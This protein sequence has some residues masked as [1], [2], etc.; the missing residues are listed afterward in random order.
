MKKNI[1]IL[2]SLIL[3]SI[4]INSAFTKQSYTKI[5]QVSSFVGTN[6][7][8]YSSI[9]KIPKNY[10]FHFDKAKILKFKI[11]SVSD[12]KPVKFII[13]NL[14]TNTT[15]YQISEINLT[16][17]MKTNLEPGNYE[18]YIETMPGKNYLN[19]LLT[20]NDL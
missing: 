5:S 11:A 3:F 15:L 20:L 2:I 17:S 10:N 1:Y 8:N 19:Y 14:N 7:S 9:Q 12:K 16:D 4:S 18:I 13:K 6:T